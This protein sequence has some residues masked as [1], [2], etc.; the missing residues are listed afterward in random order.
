MASV[1]AVTTPA[2][3]NLSP[4][5]TQLFPPL[6]CTVMVETKLEKRR[7]KLNK[8]YETQLKP[9]PNNERHLMPLRSSC[10]ASL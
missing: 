9:V 8:L 3:N 7:K 4:T 6:L 2:T 5:P 10:R 1:N